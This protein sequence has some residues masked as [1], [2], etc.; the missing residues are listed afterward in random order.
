MNNLFFGCNYNYIITKNLNYNKEVQMN[1]F[2]ISLAVYFHILTC[3][4]VMFY[5]WNKIIN[6]LGKIQKIRSNSYYDYLSRKR[7]KDVEK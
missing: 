2:Q 1:N 7:N 4:T 5:I 3:L 6:G